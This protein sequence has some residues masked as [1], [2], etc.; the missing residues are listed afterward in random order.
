MKNLFFRVVCGVNTFT[1]AGQILKIPVRNSFVEPLLY[2]AHLWVHLFEQLK[3]LVRDGVDRHATVLMTLGPLDEAPIN[4]FVN[5]TCHIRGRVQ[6]TFRELAPRMPIRMNP[7]ED[8]KHIVVAKLKVILLTNPLHSSPDVS[9][10]DEEV[11]HCL[12]G[13]ILKRSCLLDVVPQDLTHL[14]YEVSYI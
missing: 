10:C 9:R 3:A 12:L 11:Q 8:A 5:Q 1:D 13:L 7:S 6:H 14:Q 2:G 4:E